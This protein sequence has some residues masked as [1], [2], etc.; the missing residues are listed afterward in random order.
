MWGKS[1]FQALLL[2]LAFG[3]GT[4]VASESVEAAM[5]ACEDVS[6]LCV[7]SGGAKYI[8]DTTV[9]AKDKKKRIEKAGSSL[10]M[11]VDGGR[12]SLFVNGRYAGTAPLSSIPIPA[13][14]NDIQV[15][16]GA[17]VISTGV[18]W[19]PKGASVG[20]TVRHP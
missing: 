11:T 5:V 1:R 15:R 20:V 6:N 3:L 16:D 12:G 9:A 2:A 19:V 17:T 7:D 4:G 10:S 18:L 14:P 8:G 13:G